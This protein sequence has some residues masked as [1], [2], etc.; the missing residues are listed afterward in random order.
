VT[1][2]SLS[3]YEWKL[4]AVA[5]AQL[6]QIEDA[7]VMQMQSYNYDKQLQLSCRRILRYIALTAEQLAR[8]GVVVEEDDDDDDDDEDDEEEASGAHAAGSSFAA[9]EDFEHLMDV[10]E[11]EDEIDE[12]DE[13]VWPRD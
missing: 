9:A 13:E 4:R 10:D 7:E 5:M 1:L 6:M 12:N 3:K 11:D 2:E 8:D